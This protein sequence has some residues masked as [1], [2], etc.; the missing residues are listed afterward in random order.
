MARR[1]IRV[2]VPSSQPEAF[3]KLLNTIVRKHLELGAAS[4][5]ANDPDIDMG[6]FATNVATADDLRDKSED[7][8]SKSG[9]TMLQANN[10]YGTSKGQ[11]IFTP[12]TL[13]NSCD[14][15]KKELLKKYKGSEESLAIFGYDV[16]VGQAKSPT[17]RVAKKV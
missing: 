7:F 3:S 11:T 14:T 8:R 10:I 6:L 12:N 5:L 13:L 9:E 15:I 4:P 2:T 17:P 1:T 16:V